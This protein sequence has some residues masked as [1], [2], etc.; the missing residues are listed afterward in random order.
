MTRV[1]ARSIRRFV[2]SENN[3]GSVLRNWILVVNDI[4]ELDVGIIQ[5]RDTEKN[6][7][8]G[9][10]R[11]GHAGF[12]DSTSIFKNFAISASCYILLIY[13]LV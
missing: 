12:G 5:E 6:Q 4:Q 2:G 3:R 11:V 9:C 13:E 10:Y 1:N 7:D 8:V